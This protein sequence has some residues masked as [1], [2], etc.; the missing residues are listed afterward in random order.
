MW[1][2]GVPITTPSSSGGQMRTH[3]SLPCKVRL[4]PVTTPIPDHLITSNSGS[5]N[6]S[7]ADNTSSSSSGSSDSVS[8]GNT[9]SDK[10]DKSSGDIDSASKWKSSTAGNG[11][12]DISAGTL[13]KSRWVEFTLKEGRNRQVRRMAHALGYTVRA[14]HRPQFCGIGMNGLKEPGDWAPLTE[15]EL[16]LLRK[17]K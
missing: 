16:E 17:R 13:E 7:N 9:S 1:A 2:N 5:K 12:L 14:L 10:K 4:L 3:P 15:K 11:S 6:A 8:G